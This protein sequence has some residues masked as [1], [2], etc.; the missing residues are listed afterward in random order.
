MPATIQ[1]SRPVFADMDE[2]WAADFNAVTVAAAAVPDATSG[3]LGVIQ[4]AGDLDGSATLPRLRARTVTPSKLFAA[5]A[6]SVWGNFAS[7]PGDVQEISI[8]SPVRTFLQA[9]TAEEA[10]AAIGVG[11][12]GG[13][14][15]DATQ[16][17][18]QLIASQIGSV[19]ATSITG[20]L[21]AGQ[22]GSVN[23]SVIS[24]LIQATQIQSITAG[25][26][27]GQL[28]ASQIGSV[29]AASIAGTLTAGQIGTV[30]ATAIT[31]L[32][33]ATQ[34]NSLAA[35]QITGSLTSNQIQ[36]L[37]VSKLTGL[38]S[39]AQIDTLQASQITG[40]I[41]AG[42]ISS[43]AANQITGALTAGQIGAVNASVI[44][45]VILTSQL[46][47]GV[48][49]SLRLMGAN[50]SFR[51]VARV[52][53]LPTLPN[54]DYPQGSVTLRT[55]DRTFWKA[56][57]SAWAQV[58]ASD[59]LTGALTAYDITSVNA[60]TINGLITAAQIESVN[61]S[62]ITGTIQAGQIATIAATQITGQISAT[63]IAA[64]N[65]S[66][67]TGSISA[68]QIGSVNASAL[69]GLISSAQAAFG[70][71][72]NM[73][74]N[75]GPFLTSIDGWVGGYNST[76]LTQV[77]GNAVIDNPG[78][79]P[80]GNG[81]A[82][83]AI[84][85]TPAA[86]SFE[87]QLRQSSSGLDLFPVISGSRY[88][89][90]VYVGAHR[91]SAS[92]HIFWFDSANNFIAEALGGSFSGLAGGANLANWHRPSI[93]ATA[94]ANARKVIVSVRGTVF[95]G[96]NNPCLFV[97]RAHF[98]EAATNQTEPTPWA[99][100]GIGVGL[101]GGGII[102]GTISAEKI[103]SV[104][105]SAITGGIAANQITSVAAASITGQVS[106]AQIAS[107]AAVSITGAITA[108]QIASVNAA[109]ITGTIS[110]GQIAAVNAAAISGTISAAQIGSI[111]AASMTIGLLQDSQIAGLNAGKL[112]AGT[113]AAGRI[114]AG[115]ITADKLSVTALSTVSADIGNI[116]AGSVD[117]G[118]G[119]SRSRIQA[120]SFQQGNLS[121][122]VQTGNHTR[123]YL[124][125]GDGSSIEMTGY[126]S[127]VPVNFVVRDFS[128]NA[129]FEVA[130]L[131][132]TKIRKVIITSTGNDGDGI[133]FVNDQNKIFEYYGI[134]L[135]G[136]GDTW[137]VRIVNAALVLGTPSYGSNFSGGRIYFS[138]TDVY[139]YRNG[140]E[141]WVNDSAG[142][143]R[144]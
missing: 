94:P 125:G 49:N 119:L 46:A 111:D 139:L 79:N 129:A 1:I 26:I 48:V 136:Q 11:I 66:S 144:I 72:A 21:L 106:A 58:Q 95:S 9:S 113:I 130:Y 88:E 36:S 38:I 134:N 69:A 87:I 100:G 124:A 61:A 35:N 143:R 104:N 141:L 103:G 118:A 5:A 68:G 75:A 123:L 2:L 25:L 138:G 74:P 57:P 59:E 39:A 131:A 132:G 20:A 24:G 43:L 102:N 128:G 76:G 62:A 23:A 37:A 12:G 86:G 80:D 108:G 112:N 8:S 6:F 73:M 15:I 10:R 27:T 115:T 16:I 51:L 96:Q 142:A 121:V 89:A 78:W 116:T 84:V 63:Q 4:L 7:A 41:S 34:I 83:V 82:Y 44:N 140:S 126:A 14:G 77:V 64:V 67:I 28:T 97:C 29:N 127:A 47:D 18:G 120:G 81:A 114:G 55:S 70:V 52:A 53:A 105:A 133:S 13:G 107:V 85:G 65:A 135:K 98:G 60:S 32:I 137:P 45:G 17:T 92:I 22:I 31:G 54:V 50:S 91:C 122:T 42:Q 71:G 117:L 110:A 101:N 40:A 30:N 90:S 99:P 93:F 109:A 56:G 33:Q 19:N 3:A